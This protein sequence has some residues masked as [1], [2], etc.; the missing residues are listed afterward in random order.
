MPQHAVAKAEYATA[1][2]IDQF[3]HRRLLAGQA[4]VYQFADFSRQANPTFRKRR[5][6][7]VSS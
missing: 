5:L 7:L 1:E 3:D 4:T 6:A 2:A